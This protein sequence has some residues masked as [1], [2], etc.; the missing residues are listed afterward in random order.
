[1]SEDVTIKFTGGGLWDGQSIIKEYTPKSFAFYEN[2]HGACVKREYVF[3][4]R[5]MDEYVYVLKELE[6][7]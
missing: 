5:I 3:S 7:E 4:E 6:D 2:V 1:M